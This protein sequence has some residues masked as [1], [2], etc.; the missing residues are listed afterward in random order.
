MFQVGKISTKLY[1]IVGLR[2]SFNPAYTVLDVDN[3]VSRSGYYV[4]DNAYVKIEYIKDSQDYIDISDTEF[5]EYLK[6]LQQS[7]IVNV[8]NSVFNRFDYLDRNLLY[9][10]THNRVN[11]EVLPNGFVGYKI[12]VASDKDIAFEIKRVLLDFDTLGELKL[13][14]FNSSKSEPIFEQVINVTAKTQEV[15]LD[16]VVDNS[17]IT[18]KGSYYLG[19]IKDESSPIPF[20][21][22]YEYA[23]KM[24]YISHLKIERMY[25]S[26][27]AT[28][29][30]FD[31]RT[32][33]G[34]SGNIGIN[35]D[36]T[37]FEDFTDLIINNERLFS[38][39]IHLDMS[40]AILREQLNSLRI[41]SNERSAEQQSMKILAEIEGTN[42]DT[43]LKLIGLR[44]LLLGEI[45]QISQELN[46][47]KTG[48][49]NNSIKVN[50]LT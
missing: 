25:V 41:N 26:N 5:N 9:T 46:K 8:C 28:E 13:M 32:T 21:R 39:A 43:P 6:R 12:S 19:Y 48:Y 36:I 23:D 40:I 15:I 7:S 1:G 10:N 24:S 29:T 49:F 50:T 17:D 34:L 4:T 31:L 33:N 22:D 35:P 44:S 20:K 47:L 14:L 27:H 11:R 37:V 16:W 18:Y 42:G 2:D 3:Q 45:K 30:L 38:R